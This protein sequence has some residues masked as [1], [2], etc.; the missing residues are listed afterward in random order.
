M[1]WPGDLACRGRGRSGAAWTWGGRLDRDWGISDAMRRTFEGVYVPDQ[2][3][4]IVVT[5]G[6]LLGILIDYLGWDTLERAWSGLRRVPVDA[7]LSLSVDE[8]RDWGEFRMVS[9][10][11]G[12]DSMLFLQLVDRERGTG[13]SGKSDALRTRRL[14]WIHERKREERRE[15]NHSPSLEALLPLEPTGKAL[16]Q[17]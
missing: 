8:G 17:P 11:D 6:E 14:R 15:S 13:R 4:R 16:F 3:A 10:V 2:Q 5:L 7:R 12:F 1:L 9:V